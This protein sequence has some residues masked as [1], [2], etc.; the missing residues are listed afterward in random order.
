MMCTLSSLNEKDLQEI[1]KL[2]DSLNKPLLAFS[3]Q[4]VKVA[5]MSSDDLTQIQA[6][7]SKMGISLVAVEP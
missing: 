3:C 1:K 5:Q 7:E 4:N 6:L 2:E